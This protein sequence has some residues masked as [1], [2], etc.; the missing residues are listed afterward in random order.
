LGGLEPGDVAD[1]HSRHQR[2]RG[3]EVGAIG[4]PRRTNSQR[5]QSQTLSK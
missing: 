4:K 3:G 5:R 2:R 1:L